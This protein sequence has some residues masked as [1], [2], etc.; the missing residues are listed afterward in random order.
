MK[1][2]RKYLVKS[3]MPRR[4]VAAVILAAY[5]VG[6]AGFLP[7]PAFGNKKES[8][9]PFPCQD[10]PCGCASAEEC[11]THCCCFTVEQR[12]EWAASHEVTPPEYAVK[13]VSA[14]WSTARL[15]DQET[16]SPSQVCYEPATTTCCETRHAHDVQNRE[17]AQHA[18]PIQPQGVFT[19]ARCHALAGEWLGVAVVLPSLLSNC[20]L[21]DRSITERLLDLSLSPV[22]LRFVPPDPPPRFSSI[23]SHLDR[24]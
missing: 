24:P 7:L 18:R 2:W 5:S 23:R 11:W 17:P 19:V 13:P 22:L 20:A 10:H 14:E 16:Q 12:W 6:C 15:P 9:T 4:F 1:R 3:T 8:N 21:Y